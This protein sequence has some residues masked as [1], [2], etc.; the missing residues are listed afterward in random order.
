MVFVLTNVSCRLET[1]HGIRDN[2]YENDLLGL[3]YLSLLSRF[4]GAK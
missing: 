2:N 3:F 1:F 4:R